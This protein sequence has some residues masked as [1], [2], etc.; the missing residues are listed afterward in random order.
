MPHLKSH[1]KNL[2]L[3][4][5]TP[6][7]LNQLVDSIKNEDVASFEKLMISLGEFRRERLKIGLWFKEEDTRLKN[8]F[9]IDH[10]HCNP[11]TLVFLLGKKKLTQNCLKKHWLDPEKRINLDPNFKHTTGHVTN[12]FAEWHL[13]QSH[14][15]EEI[16]MWLKTN[17]NISIKER[18]FRWLDPYI[19]EDTSTVYEG[20]SANQQDWEVFKQYIQD[21]D[22]ATGHPIKNFEKLKGRYA[23]QNMVEAVEQW[24]THTGGMTHE[25]WECAT[26]EAS[27]LQEALEVARKMADLYNFNAQKRL[28]YRANAVNMIGMF[29]PN[30][31]KH[32]D[33]KT[34]STEEFWMESIAILETKALRESFSPEQTKRPTLKA[35]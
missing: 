9:K 21:P 31:F 19:I 5:I 10:R 22:I 12:T 30:L 7:M 27:S 26:G 13:A 3:L 23:V 32:K 29:N 15:Q 6:G 4:G 33:P 14:D 24:A 35:L 20:H 8:E 25:F 1:L 11:A 16:R 18:L 17:P 2:C 34:Q 28:Q